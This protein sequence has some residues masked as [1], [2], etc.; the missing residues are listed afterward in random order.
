M[1]SGLLST[2]YALK[3]LDPAVLARLKV[4]VC[5]NCDEE[6]GSPGPKRGWWSGPD[7]AAACWWPR[8]PARAGS[9]SARKG[10]AKYRITF[11]GKASHAGSAPEGDLRH[12]GA[13]PL[14]ARHQPAGQ[15]GNRYHHERGGGAGGPASTWCPTL[16]RR[17]WICASGATKRRRRCT[18]GSPSW[19][20]TLPR[21]LPGRG[22][23]PELQARDAPERRHRGPDGTGGGGRQ[24]G[25]SPF[26]LAGGRWRLRC[27]FH[28]GGRVPSSMASG[29]MGAAFTRR[30]SSCCWTASSRASACLSGCWASWPTGQR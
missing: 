1:K 25:G 18:T 15:H 20:T 24:G 7:R 19:P 26:H 17:S 21:R 9:I 5:C 8:R 14:G 16:P 29:P 13:G 2:W 30:R 10:N 28:R 23:A 12:H 27:Q 3:E 22:G 11:H 6:I 4:L